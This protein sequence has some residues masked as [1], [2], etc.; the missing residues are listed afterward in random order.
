MRV[1]KERY[2]F[3]EVN[4]FDTAQISSSFRT[5]KASK[6]IKSMNDF[7]TSRFSRLKTFESFLFLVSFFLERG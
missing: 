5:I 1:L 2:V 3:T 7:R 4:S 6:V